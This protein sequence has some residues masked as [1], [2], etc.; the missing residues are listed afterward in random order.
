MRRVRWEHDVDSVRA[1]FLAY[2][3]W[4]SD[5]RDPSPAS[6]ERVAAGLAL[7]DRLVADLVREYS[8]PHGDILLWLDGDAVVACGALREL[9]PGIAEI[10]RVHIRADY[11][12]GEFGQPFVR[13][14]I[15]RARELGFERVRADC[16]PTMQGAIEF[17]TDLGFRPVAAYWPHPAEGALFFE[18]AVDVPK[19][20]STTDVERGES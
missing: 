10:R 12:G 11:R 17:Y 15:A 8:P 7:I 13:A 6:E 5:H 3:D 2:R 19:K 1:L 16:L 4:V 20:S 9:K 18:R 14:L